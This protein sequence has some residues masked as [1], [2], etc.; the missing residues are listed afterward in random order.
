[1]ADWPLLSPISHD[2][3]S[4]EPWDYAGPMSPDASPASPLPVLETMHSIGVAERPYLVTLD[5]AGLYAS[6]VLV[7]VLSASLASI[8][9]QPDTDIEANAHYAVCGAHRATFDE[10]RWDSRPL[11]SVQLVR[12][13]VLQG[14]QAIYQA[15]IE[16]IYGVPKIPLV[17]RG[18]I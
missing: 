15:V 5:A 4:L 18:S 12:I 17:R 9:W 2:T 11:C 7:A 13:P 14:E 1:M 8:Y 6:D 3:I 10:H 16:D